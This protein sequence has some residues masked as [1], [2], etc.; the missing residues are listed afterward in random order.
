[1]RRYKRFLIGQSFIDFWMLQE[2]Y[3][4]DFFPLICSALPFTLTLVVLLLLV[5]VGS[6]SFLIASQIK[7]LTS[8]LSVANFWHFSLPIYWT[9]RNHSVPCCGKSFLVKTLKRLSVKSKL[10]SKVLNTSLILHMLF[11]IL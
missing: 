3:S 7:I 1:M 6:F 2:F 4:S 10:T 8:F 11:W 5:N 9:S